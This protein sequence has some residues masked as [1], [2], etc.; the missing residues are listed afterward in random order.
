MVSGVDFPVNQSIECWNYPE[1]KKDYKPLNC[2]H[3]GL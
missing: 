3:F 1:F 2:L